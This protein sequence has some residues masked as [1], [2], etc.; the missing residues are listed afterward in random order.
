MLGLLPVLVHGGCPTGADWIADKIW[1]SWQWEPEV[2][3][4]D[5]DS[6]GSGCPQREHRKKRLAGD[7]KHHPG[8]LDTWCP[9]AG[10]R[11][12]RLMIA[13]GLDVLLA[14]PREDGKRSGTSNCMARAEQAGIRVV[15]PD[16][17]EATGLPV[18]QG[19]G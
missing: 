6:C 8:T 7:D 10:P 12:N 1:R 16:R 15:T 11:R 17:W 4:A 3:L 14:F 19:V 2:V 18:E 13:S 9:G 5:W